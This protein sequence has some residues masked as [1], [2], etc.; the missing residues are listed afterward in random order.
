M[1]DLSYAQLKGLWLSAAKGTR[2][3]TNSWATLMAAIAEAESGGNPGALNPNDNGG[4]Q[5]S[6]GLWQI[7]TGTHAPP[8]PNWA[9]PG[10]NA[11]LAIGKLNSQGL[12][13]WG[14]YDSGAYKAYMNG[15]TTPDTT[16]PGN[17]A[18]TA[19]ETAAAQ[20]HDCLWPPSGSITVPVIPG[21]YSQTVLNCLVSK[22][23]GRALLAVANLL[24]GGVLLGVGFGFVAAFSK[25]G[26]LVLAVATSLPGGGVLAGG[27][28]KAGAAAEGKDKAPA[29]EQASGEAA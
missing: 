20:S 2:Y 10:E 1:A 27:A 5:S 19:T 8:A 22:S 14:T 28:R 7:S 9:D 13:A 29:Q 17:P 15:A 21:V 11:K 12:T 6:Y 4:T 16:I 23:E 24:L 3:D 26:R 25:P 18:A